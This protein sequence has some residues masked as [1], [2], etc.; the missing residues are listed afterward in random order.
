M[1][2]LFTERLVDNL[3]VNGENAKYYYIKHSLNV[4]SYW[5]CLYYN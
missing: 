5:G 4:A 2:L 3:K 1:S